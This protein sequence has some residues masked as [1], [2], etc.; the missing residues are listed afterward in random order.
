MGNGR[1]REERWRVLKEGERWRTEEG[2]RAG[3]EK[4][5]WWM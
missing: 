4:R 1:R 5:E 3:R 2:G